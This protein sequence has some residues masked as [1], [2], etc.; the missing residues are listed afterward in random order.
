[1]KGEEVLSRGN[2]ILRF[3]KNWGGVWGQHRFYG[4][5]TLFVRQEY[6]FHSEIDAFII[7]IYNISGPMCYVRGIA[8]NK[9]KTNLCPDTPV[10]QTAQ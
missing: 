8:V 7:S 1:M 6:A 4:Q 5:C 3:G 2:L 10:L 9:I